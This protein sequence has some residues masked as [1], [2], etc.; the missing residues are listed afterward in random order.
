MGGV[1]D[2]PVREHH[3]PVFECAP[4]RILAHFVLTM[5]NQIGAIGESSQVLARC[6]VNTLSGSHEA[7]VGTAG[8]WSF[9]ADMT[10]A[11]LPSDKLA[12]ELS[13]LPNV[14]DVKFR[15]RRT[16]F[17]ADTF[18]FPPRLVGPIL[19]MSVASVK[20]MFNHV[21]EI[22]GT[23]SV[24]DVLIHQLGIANGKG[25]GESIESLFGKRPSREELEEYLHLIRVAG[26]GVETLKELDFETSTARI[27]VAHNVE[28]S[29]Y[30]QSSKPQSQFVRGSYEAQFSRLFGKKVDAEEVS[31]IGKGDA[32]C[33]FIVKPRENS[34]S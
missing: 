11:T 18:H 14:L 26:W 24:G 13:R 20:E 5:R 10:G 16:G 28:C 4:N 9:F 22:V 21:R 27:Q 2:I 17:I 15:V 12:E 34:A 19:I 25:I 30:S 3:L 33:E 6:K 23:G 1:D 29:F 8:T 32:V 31:C 7:P